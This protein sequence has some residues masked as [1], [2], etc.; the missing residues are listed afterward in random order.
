MSYTGN[1]NG[2]YKASEGGKERRRDSRVVK[3][4]TRQDNGGIAAW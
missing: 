2:I 4:G 1:T 3:V